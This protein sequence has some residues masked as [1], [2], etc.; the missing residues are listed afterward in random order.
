[1]IVLK[2]E[3]QILSFKRLIFTK[4]ISGVSYLSVTSGQIQSKHIKFR[5]HMNPIPVDGHGKGR[6]EAG[7][8]ATVSNVPSN[9]NGSLDI[10]LNMDKL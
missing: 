3:L 4:I 9:S 2:S 1:M 8:K 6:T 7:F 10:F 5:M